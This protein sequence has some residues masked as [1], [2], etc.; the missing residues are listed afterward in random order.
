MASQW[1]GG[2]KIKVFCFF[3][4]E[5][6]ILSYFAPLG[7]IGGPGYPFSKPGDRVVP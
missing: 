5:K 3:S 1:G 6:K 2:G 4:S 7:L